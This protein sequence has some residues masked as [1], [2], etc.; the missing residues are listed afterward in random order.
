MEQ[1]TITMPNKKAD[2]K[3]VYKNYL[4]KRLLL[5]YP[6]LVIDGIDTEESNSS[7]QFVGPNDKVYFGPCINPYADVC[8]YCS[9]RKSSLFADV[10][11]YNIATDF[12]RA[13]KKLDDYYNR[14]LGYKKLYDFTLKDGTP[15][16]EYQ[17]F[18]QIG[19]K[20]IPKDNIYNTIRFMSDR[21]KTIILNFIN[22]INIDIDEI[23][24]Y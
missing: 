20:L 24:L 23:N 21:D 16:K 5:S 10:E 7:Y 2:P 3:G 19:Y 14:K 1:F 11:N 15:V 8:K 18:I 6:E 4:L 9:M 22:I 13:M 12:E 17:N